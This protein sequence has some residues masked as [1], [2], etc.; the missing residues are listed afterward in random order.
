MYLIL[1]GTMLLNEY[2]VMLTIVVSLLLIFD[3]MYCITFAGLCCSYKMP[4]LLIIRALKKLWNELKINILYNLFII[5]CL[6][7]IYYNFCN[8][9][10]YISYLNVTHNFIYY[11][12]NIL[13]TNNYLVIVHIILCRNTSHKTNARALTTVYFYLLNFSI[14]YRSFKG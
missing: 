6:L 13:L 1:L 5:I 12:H 14:Y 11:L 4:K 9:F 8:N 7:P 3:I 10:Y 2:N